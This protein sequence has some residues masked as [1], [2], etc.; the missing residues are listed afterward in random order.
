MF[1]V[2]LNVEDDGALPQVFLATTLQKYVVLANNVPVL[3]ELELTV[4]VTVAGK[5]PEPK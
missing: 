2:K 1:V 5:L 3:Y 4:A